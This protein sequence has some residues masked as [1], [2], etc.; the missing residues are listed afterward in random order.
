[1]ENNNYRFYVDAI[2]GDAEAKLKKINDLMDEIEST[3]RKG[4]DNF[5]HSTQKDM[6]K[7]IQSMQELQ[8]LIK[9]VQSEMNNVK[10][11]KIESGDLWDASRLSRDVQQLNKD[12][13]KSRTIFQKTADNRTN[14]SSLNRS[15]IKDQQAYSDEI[16]ESTKRLEKL[17]RLRRDYGRLE[18]RSKSRATAASSA[19]NMTYQ[20]AQTFKKEH[21]QAN[22]DIP[23]MLKQNQEQRDA[24][25]TQLKKSYADL[26]NINKDTTMNDHDRNN[27]A[28]ALKENIKDIYAEIEARKK[29]DSQ[30]KQTLGSINQ[31]AESMEGV[32]VSADRKSTKGILSSRAPSITMAALSSFIAVGA[33]LNQRG[34]TANSAMREPSIS[35]GQRTGNYDFRSLKRELQSAG[36]DRSLGYKGADMLDFQNTVLSNT[37]FTSREDLTGSTEAMAKGTRAVPVD[38]ESLDSFMA[39]AMQNGSISGADQIK[40]VQKG[41]LGA[42]KQSGMEGREKDQLAALEALSNQSFSGRNG[43]K[44]DLNNLM[45][46]QAMMA[47]S[48]DRSMQGSAGAEALSG[49]DAG[50]KDVAN[51]PQLSLLFGRGTKYQGAIGDYELRKKLSKGVSHPD[52]LKQIMEQAEA[53]AGGSGAD[54]RAKISRFMKITHAMGTEISIDK[55]DAIYKATDGGKNLTQ[56]NLNKASEIAQQTGSEQYDKNAKGYSDS[57]EATANA[58]EAVT[59]SQASRFNENP[60][61][62]T[63]KKVNS[64]L[65]GLPMPLYALG[66]AVIATT[67]AMLTSMGMSIGSSVL[68]KATTSTFSAAGTAAGATGATA[69][70]GS[71]GTVGGAFKASGGFKNFK[72]AFKAGAS[73]AKETV[74]LAG[75]YGKDA[76]ASGGV[77]GVVKE[78]GKGVMN[79]AKN[80]GSASKGAT[81]GATAA[82]G[83]A[84]AGAVKESAGLLGKFSKGMGAVGKVASKA[85][86]PLAI[87]MSIFNVAKAKKGEKAKVAGSEAGGWGG[88]IAG[89]T[90]GTAIL[91]GVGTLI[92][93]G[94]GAFAGSKAGSWLGDKIGGAWG[95]LTGKGKTAEASEM[96]GAEKA[97]IIEPLDKKKGQGLVGAQKALS[98]E[99]KAK[100]KEEKDTSNKKI[101][102]EK[103]REAN[104]MAESSNLS[105]YSKLLDRAQAILVQAKAQ[106]GIFGNGKGTGGS[107][108][109]TAGSGQLDYLGDGQKWSN[110]NITQHDLG[111]TVAGITAEEL[112]AWID[113]VAPEGSSMRGLGSTFLEAGKQSGLDPRYLVSHAA[114]ETGWGGGYSNGDPNKGNWFGIGADDSNPDN[115]KKYGDGII[116]GAK[117]IAD[118]Y[119]SQGQTTLDSMRNNGGEHQYATD[120]EWDK[121]IASIMKGSEKYT[122]GKSQ[123]I[124]TKA[125]INVNVNGRSGDVNKEVGK[126]VGQ[127]AKASFSE[128]LNF[129]TKEMA[130]L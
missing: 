8:K 5:F 110:E 11:G 83:G 125:T 68:Q 15:I 104:N 117:W 39:G 54:E 121:K 102:A 14:M 103:K 109:G 41:F 71:G 33:S 113:Q 10:K 34:A 118:N 53:Y 124:E 84:T 119:Y 18:S 59:E 37:G 31:S 106:N 36:T 30:M 7:N 32:R 44:E 4:K 63:I 87:G 74:Q 94:I 129:F 61:N 56:E 88:A 97:S 82:A 120:P 60:I 19:G 126:A 116:G 99:N 75:M 128:Q 73:S 76:F 28:S 115:A 81:G 93:T 98:E 6:D 27:M 17:T 55:A 105:L 70:A 29:L 57:K 72:G 62:D 79:W 38:R 43:S 22:N 40:S 66:A 52:N 96:S 45:A 100:D 50:I 64:A 3:N 12:L 35:I 89:G 49:L 65:G 78:G 16:G 95:S 101:L 47:S 51:N 86:V 122:A 9:E 21:R 13:D 90:I 123:N 48:G 1:M 67:G 108:G 85:L 127:A 69:A 58:S 2:T 25:R 91:P 107:G 26:S 130:R 23:D 46:I 80:L 111:K 77:P 20:Q 112:D 114:L 92:G 24:L 42:I